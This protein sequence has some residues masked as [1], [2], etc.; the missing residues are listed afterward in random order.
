MNKLHLIIKTFCTMIFIVAILSSPKTNAQTVTLNNLEF[1]SHSNG[2]QIMLNTN[3]KVNLHKQI[4]SN[5][6]ILINLKNTSA[7][8]NINTI[9][10]NTNNI[11]N[12]IIKPESKNLQIEIN[13]KNIA[14][15]EIFLNNQPVKET[16]STGF[17][18]ICLMLLGIIIAGIMV[19]LR[20]SKKHQYS[21][22]IKK[23]KEDMDSRSIIIKRRLMKPLSH[24]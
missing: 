24:R 19:K 1:I 20:L 22:I 4:I 18:Q 16:S 5:D 12:V 7:D 11:T 13:G 10:K 21:I 2:Y 3:K 14:N 23:S 15:N 6:K 17:I 8:K 9:Y